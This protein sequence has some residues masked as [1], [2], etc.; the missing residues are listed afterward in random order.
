MRTAV[1]LMLGFLIGAPSVALSQ[2]TTGYIPYFGKNQIRYDNFDWH[3]YQTEHFEIYYYPEIEPHLERI[4]GY[5][6]SAYQHV[7]SELTCWYA[8]SA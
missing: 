3:T 8:L 5:A 4:A 1:L 2:G 7:S 6:E